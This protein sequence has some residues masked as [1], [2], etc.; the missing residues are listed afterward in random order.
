[1]FGILVRENI[2][3]LQNLPNTRFGRVLGAVR[4]TRGYAPWPPLY[5]ELALTYRC[6]L[7]CGYCY[8]AGER[9]E[10]AQE[11][12]MEDLRRIERGIRSSFRVRPRLYLFGGEPMLHPEFLDILR[13]LTRR[14][15]RVSFTTNGTLLGSSIDEVARTRGIDNLVVSINAANL[16]TAPALVAELTRRSRDSGM[17]VSLNC[18]VDLSAE[19]GEDLADIAR[20]FD[21]CGARFLSFQHSQSVFLRGRT[22]DTQDVVEQ[23]RRARSE[24]TRT[25]VTFFP[26]IRDRDLE[27]YYSD[28]AFPR[29]APGCVL[30]WFDVFVRPGGE[31]VPCDE[32]DV[33]VGNAVL[34]PLGDIWNNERFREFRKRAASGTQRHAICRRCC[35]R[36]YYG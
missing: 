13:W 4:L 10:T 7:D 33:V 22:V 21:D 11:M 24:Q 14:D 36:R 34:Q 30:P 20:R 35:H 5:V 29:K 26:E 8:Q 16:D 2:K 18:P 23:I 32:I 28:P 15:Y 27:A 31:V 25:E 6:N 12:S 19:V 17:T 3:R 1:M 9:R